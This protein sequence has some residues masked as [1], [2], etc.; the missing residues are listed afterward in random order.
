MR[1]E[2]EIQRAHDVIAGLIL[3][4]GPK[5]PSNCQPLLNTQAAVLC[6]VLEHDHNRAFSDLLKTLEKI[7]EDEGF[8]LY[9]PGDN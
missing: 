2:A 1:T 4:E 5:V 9:K 3:G 7:A 6:W 8:E